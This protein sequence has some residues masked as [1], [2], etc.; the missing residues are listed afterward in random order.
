MGFLYLQA[1]GK[2]I[3]VVL[4]VC[5]E[6]TQHRRAQPLHMRNEGIV[7]GIAGS[8]KGHHALGHNGNEGIRR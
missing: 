1:E 4:S 6:V 3:E 7:V 8:G 5:D 2:A